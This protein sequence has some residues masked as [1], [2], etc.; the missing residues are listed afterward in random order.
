MGVLEKED[1]QNTDPGAD[2][3]D[4]LLSKQFPDAQPLRETRYAISTVNK[5]DI[6]RYYN[7]WITTKK[8]KAAFSMFQCKKSPGTDGLSP[9]VLKYLPDNII[10]NIVLLYKCLIKL[11]FTPTIWKESKVVFIPKPGKD[12]YKKCKSWRAISLTNYPL[13]ALEKLCCWH[14]D[15]K[16]AQTPLHTNQHGFR[17][18]RNTDTALSNVVNYI[19]KFIN[20]GQHVLA[21][22][23]DIQAA[24]DTIKTT[25]I[26]DE[27]IKYGAEKDMAYWYYN[28]ISHRNMFVTLNGITRAIT[29]STGFPQGGVCSAKFWII[30]FNEAI[31]IINKHGVFGTGFADDCAAIVGGGNLHQQM[32]KIQKVCTELENWGRIQGLTFNALKTEVIIFT[33]ARLKSS[34][35]PNKLIM[36]DTRIDFGNSVKYLGIHLDCKLHWGLTLENKIKR[37]K[38]ML[39]MLRQATSKKW[40][41]K[42]RYIKWAYNAIV[43]ARITYGAIVWGPALR[44][45]IHRDKLNKVNILAASM[46]GNTRKSTPRIALEIMYDLPPLD[47]AVTYEA[48]ASLARNRR[49]IVRDW[50]GFNSK[51]RTLIGHTLYWEKLA[52]D[53]RLDI[54]DTDSIKLDIWEKNFNVNT[55]SF[56]NTGPPIPSQV[57]IY[58]DGSKTDEHVG[59]GFTIYIN[60]NE[61]C[62]ESIRLSENNTV[63]Q[64]EVFAIKQAIMTLTNFNRPDLQYIKLFSDSQAALLSLAQWKMKSKLVVDTVMAL[65]TLGKRCIRLELNWIKAHHNYEGNERADELARNAVYNNIIR[66]DINP[67]HSYF[68]KKLWEQVYAIWTDRWTEDKTCRMTKFFFPYCHKGKAKE[69]LKLSRKQSR[70]LIEI[71][72]GQNDLH[73]INNKVMNTDTL[74]RFC[75]EEEETFDHLVTECP[76][77]YTQRTEIWGQKVWIG[78]HDWKIRDMLKFSYT[79]GINKALNRGNSDTED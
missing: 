31:E 68:K 37:A 16:I 20:N 38:Q 1:G 73:Y 4:Y 51:F 77:F 75:E 59:S 24:F 36:G 18:D 49:V 19:E 40:G 43:K 14:T 78:T 11:H 3:I 62:Y 22:F 21:V 74:C 26:R 72:T 64:A 35:Y 71:V 60:G 63:Y 9:R 29:T 27:L 7:D 69:I 58:T 6:S 76:C 15:D 53:M 2:T 33:R 39:F 57:N 44:H 12:T 46:I 67:P 66:F 30:A 65:N 25:K 56:D 8:V 70:R 13:K 79:E 42:P 32:S 17:T 50:P 34:D 52:K 45:K 41:P 54:N 55:D 23:L 10:S 28:Y 61:F 5:R 47:L 48:I